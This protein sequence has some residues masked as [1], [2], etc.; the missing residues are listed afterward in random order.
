ML[1]SIPDEYGKIFEQDNK[2][3]LLATVDAEGYPHITFINTISA[4]GGKELVWG[5]F[6]EGMSKKNVQ[7]NAKTGFLILTLNMQFWKGKAVWKEWRNTGTEMDKFNQKPLFRYNSY[8]G[9]GKVHYMDLV[10]ISETE[11]LNKGLIGLGVILTKISKVFAGGYSGERI[12]NRFSLDLIN[13]FISLKFISYVNNEGFPVI[14]PVI[15]A[16]ASGTDR[17]IFSMTPSGEDINSIPAGVKAA[18]YCVNMKCESVLTKGVFRGITKKGIIRAGIFDIEK[19]YNS[20]LPKAGYI[21]PK[22]Q[23]NAVTDWINA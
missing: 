12:L 14:I 6:S 9:I 5:Q 15:Q 21:Y 17:I 1:N 7:S 4:N 3:G 20:M 13:Q 2:V 8:F 23:I 10:E 16:Q 11:T 18:I 22:Q 19:V